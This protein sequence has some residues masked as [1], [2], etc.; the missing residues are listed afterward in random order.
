M[1]TSSEVA[2]LVQQFT[3]EA[4]SRREIEVVTPRELIADEHFWA[5]MFDLMENV[6]HRNGLVIAHVNYIESLKARQPD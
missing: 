1:L 2:V 5:M 3:K 6:I 4:Q